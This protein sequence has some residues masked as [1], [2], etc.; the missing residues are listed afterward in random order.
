[1]NLEQKISPHVAYFISSRYLFWPI[2]PEI[3]RLE[4]NTKRSQAGDSGFFRQSNN[5]VNSPVVNK[6]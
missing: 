5:D 6:D 2:E 4:K 1:L 3:S